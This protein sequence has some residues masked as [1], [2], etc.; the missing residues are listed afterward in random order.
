MTQTTLINTRTMASTKAVK[1]AQRARVLAASSSK[2]TSITAGSLIVR[3]AASR[4][5]PP[6][7]LP[8]GSLPQAE[9]TE[10][11]LPD[12]SRF[13]VSFTHWGRCVFCR[14][15]PVL[16]RN[17]NRYRVICGMVE[18]RHGKCP[19]PTPWFKS[20]TAAIRHWKLVQKLSRR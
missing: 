8:K 9:E 2:L 1:S 18:R 7:K 6:K 12:E 15:E 10:F 14:T 19:E 5:M 11:N 3:P 13:M 17:K 16:E 4:A 20:S